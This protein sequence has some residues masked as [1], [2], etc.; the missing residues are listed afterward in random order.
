MD[1]RPTTV[2]SNEQPWSDSFAFI[3]FLLLILLL[4]IIWPVTELWRY[5][6]LY[7]RGFWVTRKGRDSIEYQE[8]RDR[9][10]RRLTIDG[11]MLVKG[12]HVVY[13]P[14]ENEWERRMP[15]WA[16]GRREEIIANVK[17]DLGTKHYK[18]VSSR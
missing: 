13:V 12:P 10:I 6:R 18:F 16:H 8:R 14:T 15:A 2:E 11:E 17:R 9:S 3:L 7:S 1:Y 5:Y 4:P